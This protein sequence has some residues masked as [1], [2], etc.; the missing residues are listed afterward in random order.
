[1]PFNSGGPLIADLDSNAV[2]SVCILIPTF[3]KTP[4]H[5]AIIMRVIFADKHEYEQMVAKFTL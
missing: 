3:V 2:G 1:M 4:H 5:I